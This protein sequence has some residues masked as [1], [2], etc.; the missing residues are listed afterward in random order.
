MQR[1]VSAIY[2]LPF[3]LLA[4][5]CEP[6]ASVPV[7]ESGQASVP[8][9]QGNWEVAVATKGVD[10]FVGRQKQ[11]VAQETPVAAKP[12]EKAADKPAEA[13]KP[14]PT[15]KIVS[16]PAESWSLFRGTA[17]SSGVTSSTLPDKLEIV[18]RFE[19]P[20]GAFES[21]AAIVGD[22]VY[23]PDLD[24]KVYCLSLKNGEKKW[25]FKSTSGFN[26]SPAVRDGKVYIG[27]TEGN[28]YC[29]DAATGE[30]K[31]RFEAKAEI[32]SSANFHGD[33]VL[34]GAQNA[35]LYCL[36]IADGAEVWKYT[37]GDQIRCS[38]TVVGD[39]AFVAGCDAKLHI[40][41][42]NKGEAA[43]A[44]EIEAQTGCTPAALGERI[45]FGT[46]A[47]TLL[48]VNWKTAKIDWTF[49]DEE[50]S[51]PFEGSA[52]VLPDMVVVGGRNKRVQAFD[53]TSGEVKWTYPT[54]QA[55][56]SSPVI[57]GERIFVGSDDGR[58]TALDRK[59]GEKVW[60]Y[61]AGGSFKSSP[62]IAQQ[63]LIIANR[64]GVVY[65]FGKKE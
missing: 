23:I 7:P 53:P 22:Y 13:P 11:A 16:S 59:S 3:S 19:V 15:A 35:T 20:K 9:G 24:G 17:L 61:E 50:R 27:D 41:D 45:Y 54:R 29:L 64:D 10:Q 36:K 39:R 43:G 57:C 12:E 4:L 34:V 18:W 42:L 30:K 25:E 32:N 28:F 55:I 49:A 5:G 58:L 46:Q 48:C 6:V 8:P 47:G 31:W 40:V 63:K 33:H 51:Q 62:A 1:K 52:A 2:L 14:D 38:I 44:V 65:C 26:A 60:E 37:I 21:T 56:E